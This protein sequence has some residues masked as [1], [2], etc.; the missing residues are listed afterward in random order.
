MHCYQLPWVPA[1]STSL[2]WC[3]LGSRTKINLLSSNCFSQTFRC[4]HKTSSEYFFEE[5]ILCFGREVLW[6]FWLA[7]RGGKARRNS[8]SSHDLRLGFHCWFFEVLGQLNLFLPTY[9]K[10]LSFCI[11]A[12]WMWIHQTLWSV[13]RVTWP[14]ILSGTWGAISPDVNVKSAQLFTAAGA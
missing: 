2:Q 13:L 5:D 6:E 12:K 3:T 9:D 4:S 10:M 7:W 1:T 14:I 8:V 11:W